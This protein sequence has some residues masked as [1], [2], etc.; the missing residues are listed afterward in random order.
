M[1]KGLHDQDRCLKNKDK[2]GTLPL[3]QSFYFESRARMRLV[4]VWLLSLK[5]VQGER[6]APHCG[7]RYRMDLFIYLSLFMWLLF[8]QRLFLNRCVISGP[9]RH[10][11]TPLHTAA[12]LWLRLQP[13]CDQMFLQQAKLWRASVFVWLPPSLLPPFSSLPIW[14]KR[15]CVCARACCL[16]WWM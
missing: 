11:C 9:L 13:G 4:S 2:V 5:V 16:C 10:I 8:L 1:N 14:G 15:A 12:H 7:W 3:L 6:G